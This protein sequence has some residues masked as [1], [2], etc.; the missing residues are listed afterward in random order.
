MRNKILGVVFAGLVALI[1]GVALAQGGGPYGDPSSDP[2]GDPYYAPRATYGSHFNILLGSNTLSGDFAPW[3][4]H[5]E[6]GLQ[7]DF[8]PPG[9]SST[10]LFGELRVSVSDTVGGFWIG[11]DEL[12]LGVRQYIENPQMP[13]AFHYGGGISF[14]SSDLYDATFGDVV[15]DSASGT[16][17]WLGLGVQF[18]VGRNMHL[19]LDYSITHADGSYDP[20]T[21]GSQNLGGSHLGLILGWGW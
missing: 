20:L 4:E 9:W 13:Y 21:F 16:G 7:F 8:S 3:D 2:Y 6:F 1:P 19:G 18:R 5:G 15:V 11:N 14:I 10:Y 12:N 17:Y